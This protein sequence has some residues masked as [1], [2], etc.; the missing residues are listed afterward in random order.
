MPENDKE[1]VKSNGTEATEPTEIDP[2]MEDS[3]TGGKAGFLHR[4]RDRISDRTGLSRNGVYVVGGLSVFAFVCF[5]VVIAL[6]ATW[7]RVPHRF[8]FPIQ[9]A[10]DSTISPCDNLWN[11]TC[12]GWLKKYPLPKDKSVWNM[13][14]QLVRQEAENVRDLIATLKLPIHT[15]TVEWKLKHLYEA[16]MD[17]DNVNV[18]GARPILDIINDL[19]LVAVVCA[20]PEPPVGYNYPSPAPLPSSQYGAPSN[21]PIQIPSH[22]YGSPSSGLSLGGFSSSGSGIELSQGGYSGLSQGGYSGI[23]QG[24]YSSISQGG[25]SG[26]SQGFSGVSQGFSGSQGYASGYSQGPSVIQSGPASVHKHVYVHVA[27]EEPEEIR[28]QRPIVVG[29]PQKHYK[30]IFIKAPSPP[31]QQAP[32]I[33]VQPQNEEKTLVYVLVKKPEEQPEIV[34]P[35]AQPTQPTKPEVYFIKYNTRKDGVSG[36][37]G[38][39]AGGVDGGS[40][41]SG[42]GSIGGGLISGG[43]SI[44]GGLISG[45]GS[46][47]GGSIDGGLI[48]GGSISDATLSS[49]GSGSISGG[50]S[51]TSGGVSS[52]YGPPGYQ[53]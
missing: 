10:L 27:P 41:I 34:V 4:Y 52:K 19:A 45:G 42:G 46:I 8:R 51:G 53:H 49:H 31:R 12:G 30:I 38:A 43:G 13:K 39:S 24:G 40:L 37:I 35:Q 11:S 5:V 17:V 32:V 44:G 48:S 21:G 29:A 23:S 33:P 6:A 9:E 15:S 36:G 26:I 14:Q 20:R 50:V 1:L 47:G 28:P 18:D 3:K 22:Q 7:P 2:C 16:C 25:L